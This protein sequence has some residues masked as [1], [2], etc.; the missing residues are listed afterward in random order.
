MS[1]DPATLQQQLAELMAVVKEE[2]TLLQQAEEAQR[3][4]EAKLAKSK[5]EQPPNATTTQPKGPKIL[6]PNKFEGSRGT[7]A[8]VYASQIGL[9]VISNPSLFPNDCSKVIFLFLYL[10]GP[11]ANWA[12]P[13]T[14]QLFAGKDLSYKAFTTTFR[15]MYFDTKKKSKAEKALRQ[16]KLSASVMP[17]ASTF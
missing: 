3:Q 14:R 1:T 4:A 15:C 6:V 9:Y 13:Y 12:Q 10:T 17:R 7:K 8:E 16:L 11:V 5:P 2:G